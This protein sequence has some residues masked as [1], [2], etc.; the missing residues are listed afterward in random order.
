MVS[1]I[2]MGSW[3]LEGVPRVIS[4]SS[5]N[6]RSLIV[7]DDV[8]FRSL[9]S[10]YFALLWRKLRA[11]IFIMGNEIAGEAVAVE[12]IV[13]EGNFANVSI[14]ETDSA[15]KLERFISVNRDLDSC[16]LIIY[17]IFFS[18]GICDLRKSF[19]I[20]EV[21]WDSRYIYPERGLCLGS[22]HW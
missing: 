16:L 4:L 7:V 11:G 5:L 6:E 19:V 12:T 14:W 21:N 2:N 8:I 3:P 9:L 17:E 1:P 22:S 10:L 15:L 13:C 18:E 20:P